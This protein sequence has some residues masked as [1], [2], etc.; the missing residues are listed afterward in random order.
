MLQYKTICYIFASL[1]KKTKYLIM[2]NKLLKTAMIVIA[3]IFFSCSSEIS[4]IDESKEEPKKSDNNQTHINTKFL[5]F[6]QKESNE[7]MA[8]N[9]PENNAIGD[10]F[11]NLNISTKSNSSS[12][13]QITQHLTATFSQNELSFIGFNQ[14]N[15]PVKL[16]L[17]IQGVDKVQTS[18]FYDKHFMSVLKNKKTELY[19][20]AVNKATKQQYIKKDNFDL[21]KQPENQTQ[22][23]IVLNIDDDKKIK[24]M[25][26]FTDKNILIYKKG[27]EIKKISCENPSNIIS[28]AEHF[29]VK[30]KGE[31]YS[32]TY[33]YTTPGDTSSKLKHYFYPVS[34][35]GAKW[36]KDKSGILGFNSKNVYRYALNDQNKV[37]FEAEKVVLRKIGSAS[38]SEIN[39]G[40]GISSS[41]RMAFDSDG[42]VYAFSEFAEKEKVRFK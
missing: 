18:F 35:K 17:V 1:L 34:I 20:V 31:Y 38:I 24:I 16:P 10:F 19:Y 41:H 40:T 22:P 33:L 32:Y 23:A 26:F 14:G 9:V 28:V 25:V 36:T 29:V 13:I 42:Y 4:D 15:M 21:S 37:G 12:L 27:K 39:V 7:L 5:V 6:S 8:Y 3:T 30:T 2:Q 11:K